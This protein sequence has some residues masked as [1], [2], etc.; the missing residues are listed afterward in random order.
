MD[1]YLRPGQDRV[2]EYDGGY[3]AV[4]S[5]P[6]AGKT[7]I[8]TQLAV[9]LIRE[10]G[11]N[12]LIVTYMNSA[13]ANFKQRISK[14]L[15]AEGLNPVDGYEVMT[16]HSLAM[17]IIKEKPDRLFINDEFQIVDEN[18][19]KSIITDV[20]TRFIEENTKM[21]YSLL[22]PTSQVSS[23]EY[24]KADMK[25]WSDAFIRL[26]GPFISYIKV[27]GWSP[28]K[29]DDVLNENGHFFMLDWC[30]EVYRM[31]QA[32]LSI[33]GVLD[34]DDILANALYALE[35]YPDILEK[36][37][38]R[39]GY[40]FEDE[41]QDSTPIQ[42]KML[43]LLCKTHGN[44]V[45]V[46]DGNQA[47]MSTFTASD[48]KLFKDFYSMDST[49][50]Q[51]I[52]LASRS[53]EKI[54]DL[55]N[56]FVSWSRENDVIPPEC[57]DALENQYIQPVD[58]TDPYPNPV[59][60]VYP[61]CCRQFQNLDD[62]MDFVAR[63][64]GKFIKKHPDK[65]V[66]VLVPKNSYIQLL[67]KKLEKKAIPYR[68]L[69]SYPKDRA[70]TANV[71]GAFLDYL[72]TPSDNKK[73]LDVLNFLPK[74]EDI[75][76]S[77][78]IRQFLS[79]ANLEDIFYPIDSKI[80]GDMLPKQVIEE[81]LWAEWEKWQEVFKEL[82]EMSSSMPEYLVLHI[83]ERLDFDE[84]QM[85]IAQKVAGDIRY[86]TMANPSWSLK[87]LAEEL[88]N[89]K[90]SYNY[91][92]GVV[93]DMEGYEPKAGEVTIAT[94]HK[95][96]GLEWDGVF[97]T[98][99]NTGDFQARL[100][101]PFMGDLN[102][103]SEEYKN[104]PAIIRAEVDRLTGRRSIDN[105]II[106]SRLDTIGEKMRLLYVGITRAKIS[107]VITASGSTS[108]Y[109]NVLAKYIKWDKTRALGGMHNER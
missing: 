73:L 24:R 36:Y 108:A 57:L 21:F 64:V 87:D 61:L 16:L 67:I 1:I 98:C 95:S 83:G 89:I 39:Y 5:V 14:A 19:Q 78:H 11:E 32:E 35:R 84:Q 71:I 51:P 101:D 103:L 31:Y 10:T 49:C 55:A 77:R 88:K 48:P 66:A 54:I 42:Q 27:A 104:A 56:Y 50:I 12:I 30:A 47:I 74:F 90:N 9:K 52:W 29:L 70:Y 45:R 91:F 107:L 44:L 23:H 7:F 63:S 8:L 79:K 85:A 99:L 76:G 109:Y 82:M 41:A 100:D 53:C 38:N 94:Y 46:G 96:K 106:Q 80:D 69:T 59:P 40:I 62:E 68:E 75:K 105:A 6:G 2:M 17:K 92:A 102:M 13:V 86:F 25:K 93:Y 43:M 15:E 28:D 81:G 97:L 34:F 60:E 26:V 18:E 4:P 37:Q 72:S 20:C 58:R 3:L 65:T 33:R 22:P